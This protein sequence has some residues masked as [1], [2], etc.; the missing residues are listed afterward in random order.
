MA[1]AA[2]MVGALVMPHNI[3]LHSAL[4][5]SRRIDLSSTAAKREAILYNAIE[6]GMSLGVTVVINLSLMAVFAEGFHGQGAGLGI[7]EVGLSSAGTCVPATHAPHAHVPPPHACVACMCSG[8][9][10]RSAG[11]SGRGSARR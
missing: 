7:S 9:G 4:V 1:V 6:S 5:Q 3:F 10:C 8:D 11:T 2:G